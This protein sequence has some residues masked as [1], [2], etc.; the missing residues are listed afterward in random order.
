MKWENVKIP[1]LVAALLWGGVSRGAEA[2]SVECRDRLL[3]PEVI[4]PAAVG[5]G[6]IVAGAAGHSATP[7]WRF[8]DASSKKASFDAVEVL[9]YAPLAFPWI[10]KAA[11]SPTRSGWGRMAVSQGLATAIMGATVYTLKHTVDS[12][13]PDHSDD[14]SFPSGHAAWAFMGATM[15]ARELGWRSPWYTVGA[16]TLATG[17]AVQRVIDNRHFPTD[18]VAGA[19]IGILSAQ[20]GY[21]LGD[22][23]FR[24]SQLDNR[25]TRRLGENNNLSFMSLQIGMGIPLGR[26][27]VNGG[28]ILRLPTLM[29]GVSSGFAVDDHWGIKLDVGLQSTPLQIE[30]NLERTHVA[31]LNALGAV[32]APYY[33]LPLSR[34]VAMLADL[35]AGYFFNFKV[36]SVDNAIAASA[37]TPVGRLNVGTEIRFDEHFRCNASLGYE[38]SGYKFVIHPSEAYHVAAADRSRGLQSSLLL[39]VSTA[40]TF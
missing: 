21:F 32:V 34:R 8:A 22:L 28:K 15:T 9:Q 23:I 3:R 36:N 29:A 6:M 24:D 5:A 19:G 26:V 27:S 10:M 31:N 7:S 18:V 39:N 40:V 37:G 17:I 14:R 13:R 2:D 12:P 1:V 25:V 35:G 16:Y 4:V 38:L 30:Q 11:G 20:M 33:R